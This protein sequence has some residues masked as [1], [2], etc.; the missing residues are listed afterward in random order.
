MKRLEEENRKSPAERRP[1]E[2]GSPKDFQLIQALNKLKGL[3]VVVSKT[4]VER[5]EAAKERDND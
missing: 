3:P 2:F 4:Q 5:K 1:P